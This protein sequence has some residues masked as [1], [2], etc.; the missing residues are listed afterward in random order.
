MQMYETA[1]WAHLV[2]L[3]TP[4]SEA[5]T[6]I[7]LLVWRKHALNFDAK[8]L[9]RA[10]VPAAAVLV[11]CLLFN[12]TPA[13]ASRSVPSGSK[14]GEIELSR[15]LVGALVQEATLLQTGFV[16]EFSWLQRS[17]SRISRSLLQLSF[18]PSGMAMASI[19]VV[20]NMFYS[21]HFYPHEDQAISSTARWCLNLT[22]AA[23]GSLAR[24]ALSG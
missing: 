19:I 17:V 6:S 5:P 10:M 22:R 24:L 14:T 16:L 11:L 1:Q 23:L 18:T 13:S 8:R 12:I 20:L 21:S 9:Q 4:T 7:P 2:V 3:K 15:T